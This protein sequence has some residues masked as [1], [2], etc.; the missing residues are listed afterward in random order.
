[1][2]C[3]AAAGQLMEQRR[4]CVQ[5]MRRREHP[6]VNMRLCTRT[7]CALQVMCLRRTPSDLLVILATDGLWDVFTNEEAHEAAWARFEKELGKGRAPQVRGVGGEG[8]GVRAARS[9]LGGKGGG[10]PG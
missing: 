3:H 6:L 4:K 9:R 5:G 8:Y 2:L 7:S 10:G 1:M